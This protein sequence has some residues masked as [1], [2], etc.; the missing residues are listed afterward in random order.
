MKIHVHKCGESVQ[1]EF[2][3]HL[4]RR[5]KFVMGKFSPLIARLELFLCDENGPRGG[6]DKSCRLVTRLVRHG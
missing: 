2:E 3:G 4:E 5:V 6:V 1:G